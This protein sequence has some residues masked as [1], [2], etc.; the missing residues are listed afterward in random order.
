MANRGGICAGSGKAA[1]SKNRATA[2]NKEGLLGLANPSSTVES[3][4]Y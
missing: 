3:I 4:S 1:D 2:G